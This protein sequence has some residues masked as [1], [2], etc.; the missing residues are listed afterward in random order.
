MR[1]RNGLSHSAF[2]V[3]ALAGFTAPA[4]AQL[5]SIWGHPAFTIGGTPYDSV[6]QGHGNYPGSPGFIPGYGYYHG[7]CQDPWIDGPATPFDRHQMY[8]PAGDIGKDWRGPAGALARVVVKLPADAELWFDDFKATQRGTYREFI[9]PI[10]AESEYTL[11]V[12]WQTQGAL[13]TRS[14]YARLK[15]GQTVTL[16]FLTVEGWSGRK[17]ASPAAQRSVEP[18]WLP[19]KTP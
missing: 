5:M 9:A 11:T 2:A 10:N 1:V 16:N 19:R 3:A 8:A 17:L 7:P 14:Q 4:M 15:P 18:L 13:L 6:N 12:R